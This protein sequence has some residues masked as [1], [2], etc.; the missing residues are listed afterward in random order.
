MS[1]PG[2]RHQ[3]PAPVRR[4]LGFHLKIAAALAALTTVYSFFAVLL[5]LSGFPPVGQYFR[6]KLL[7]HLALSDE[8]SAAWLA[9]VDEHFHTKLIFVACLAAGLMAGALILRAMRKRQLAPTVHSGGRISSKS[10]AQKLGG[11][12]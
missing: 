12:K 3:A 7:H 4:P 9:Q 2:P 11:F 5:L 10:T 8:R 6:L 1:T